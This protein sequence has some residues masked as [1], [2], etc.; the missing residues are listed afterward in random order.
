M[1]DHVLLY[2]NGRRHQVSGTDC[3]LSLSD[4]LRL[5]LGLVGTKIVC[6]EGDCGSCTVLVGR[7]DDDRF[8]YRPIDSCIHWMFQLDGTHVVSVE[9]LRAGGQ[10]TP[11][12]E[13]MIHC[14]GSQC[15]YCTPGFVV[16]MTGLLERQERLCEEDLRQGLTGNLCRCTGYVPILDAGLELDPEAVTRINDVYPPEAMLADIESSAGD[17]LSIESSDP[18]RT[19]RLFGPKSIA[20]VVQLMG[21][22]PAA[23]I[24]AGATDVGVQ[25]NKGVIDPDVLVDLN[26]VA[27]LEGVAIEVDEQGETL[28][29]GARA[30]WTEIESACR[31]LVPEFHS[32]VSIFGSPQIRHAG[33]IGGNVVNASPI[34][35]SL[36]FL[37]VAGA[38]LELQGAAGVR[39]LDIN[40]FYHGYK[41]FD[42]QPGELLTRVRVPLPSPGD[43]LR[44]VKVSRRRDLD[45][46][47]FTAAIWM[48]LNGDQI[49]DVRLA[50]GAVG[51]TIVRARRTE[52]FLRGRQF[53]ESTMRAAGDVAVGEI[54]PISDVRGSAE[55]RYQLT[56]N[57]LLKFYHEQALAAV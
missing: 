2:I 34:A 30:T 27:E 33:T 20:E 11:V 3:F 55:Y 36:P 9:G 48:R 35:D 21:Q 10:L 22:Y 53:T 16:A 15:G 38:A 43:L 13:A 6:S 51:P 25:L 57:V 14:H 7:P 46:A 31:D 37:F 29:A 23:K 39:T 45:I 17:S 28:V 26:R 4:F 32:I 44:L 24:V 56:R 52:E 41:K 49:A 5:R 47:T 18:G 42:L 19:R 8:D 1:R 12:Q 54:T 50:F 40:D